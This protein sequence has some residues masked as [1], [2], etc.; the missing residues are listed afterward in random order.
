MKRAIFLAH[1]RE[2]AR[3]QNWELKQAV[4][5]AGA[6]GYQGLECDYTDLI[7]DAA[8]FGRMVKDM[9]MEIS[10]V[11][12]FFNFPS[13]VDRSQIEAAA[14]RVA[15]AGGRKILA[16]P[17]EGQDPDALARMT[18]GLRCLCE[19]A[20]NSGITVTLEDFDNVK[21]PCA[22]AEGLAYFFERIPALGFTLD[23]GNFLYMDQD[24]TEC[25]V[26][27]LSRLA[28]MHL[29]DRSL[30]PLNP[31]EKPLLSAEGIPLYPCPVGR[32]V[33]PMERILTIAGQAGYTDYVTVEHFGAA[34]QWAYAAESA[35]WLR[36]QRD[37]SG[38][39]G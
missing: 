25:C 10:N 22:T 8:A 7:P 19:A 37:S 13:G 4:S 30:V 26:P 6:L 17:G 12:C 38:V 5:K 2:A 18:E 31:R 11:C 24:V 9:G 16:I 36:E 15:A 27:L 20:G 32:G 14:D 23:T 29:K 34:D 3:Q 1:L 33:I 35:A 21:S 28:H 39:D